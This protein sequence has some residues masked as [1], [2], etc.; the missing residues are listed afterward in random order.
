MKPVRQIKNKF[1]R[2]KRVDSAAVWDQRRLDLAFE[3]LPDEG[4]AASNPWD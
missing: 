1:L 2:P 3:A 4:D